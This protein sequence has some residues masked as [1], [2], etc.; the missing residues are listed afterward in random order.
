MNDVSGGLLDPRMLST[1]ADLQV[2]Y[3]CM[4][5]GRVGSHP[6]LMYGN[7]SGLLEDAK[8]SLNVKL[9]IDTVHDQLASRVDACRAAGISRWNIVIDPGFGFGKSA[10]VNFALVRN[11][12]QLR[13]TT[14][15]SYPVMVGASRKRFVRDLV[16]GKEWSGSL[17][18]A[19]LGTV[20]I[21]V[22]IQNQAD[23]HRVHDVAELK[24]ALC[25]SDR[26]FRN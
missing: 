6:P 8:F 11:I 9:A 24:Y 15:E 23:I 12:S 13:R 3:I 16:A 2:P 5:A 7:E 1:V 14:L 22:A 19:M 10:D 18:Q 20:A 4:H 26:V 21:A 17:E 25:V